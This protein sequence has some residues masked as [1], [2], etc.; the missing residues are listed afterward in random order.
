MDETGVALIDAAL[1]VYL[2]RGWQGASLAEIT[3]RAGLT[4][5]AIY[6]RFTG[7]NELFAA[8]LERELERMNTEV[9]RR[10][11]EVGTELERLAVLRQWFRERRGR[12]GV[13]IFYDL[14]HQAA[15]YP[16]LRKALAAI[17]E[18][19]TDA[20]AQ[21]LER[22]LGPRLNALGLEA[23]TLAVLSTAL[24]EG[25]LLRQFL[26]QSEEPVDLVFDVL[27]RWLAPLL[28]D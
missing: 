22:H 7:K 10:L 19:M 12:A 2:E 25:L 11:G 3:N 18:R 17:Y 8:V 4:T 28:R 1:E 15:E 24:M 9:A 20:V 21:S 27:E 6:S 16:R 13:R 26:T 23:R 5:G 14:W